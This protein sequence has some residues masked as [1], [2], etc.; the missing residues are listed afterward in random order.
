MG[1]SV[2]TGDTGEARQEY[3]PGAPNRPGIST[4]VSDTGSGDGD[5]DDCDDTPETPEATPEATPISSSPPISTRST[6]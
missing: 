2:A 3:R 6:T 4:Q 5:G 1:Y